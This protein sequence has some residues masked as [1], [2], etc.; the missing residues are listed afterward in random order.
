MAIVDTTERKKNIFSFTFLSF[1]SLSF[2][3]DQKQTPTL[4]SC[5][6]E[7]YINLLLDQV[8]KSKIEEFYYMVYMQIEDVANLRPV[9]ENQ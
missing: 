9:I 8:C 7:G 6:V 1:P 5:Q 4:I 2:W 3:M